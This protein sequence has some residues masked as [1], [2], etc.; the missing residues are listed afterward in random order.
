VDEHLRR[1]T[2]RDG[3]KRVSLLKRWRG[4]TLLHY[5]FQNMSVS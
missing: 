2:L 3:G 4:F 5:D 1:R